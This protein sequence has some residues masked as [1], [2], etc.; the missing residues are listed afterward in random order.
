MP[1]TK[2]PVGQLKANPNNPRVIRDDKFQRLVKSIK[3]FP[4]ML[5]A[6]P[7]VVNPDNIV[8]G[9]NMRLRAIKELKLKEVPVYVAS[10]SEVQEKEFTIKDNVGFG[11]W[12]WDILANEWDEVELKDW[13][14]DVWQPD[15]SFEVD[16]SENQ[17][18]SSPKLTDDDYSVFELVMLHENKVKLL[19]VLGNIKAQYDLTTNEEA[20]MQ[21]V[22]STQQ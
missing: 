7:I 10:W 14:L 13:G 4:E 16:D 3:D 12:D 11:E 19:A 22:N 2:L 6:R 5:E 15:E 20:L 9:G 8:L 21:L 17:E 18:Q 1:L